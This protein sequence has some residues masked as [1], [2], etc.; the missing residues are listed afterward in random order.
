MIAFHELIQPPNADTYMSSRADALLSDAS[1]AQTGSTGDSDTQTESDRYSKPGAIGK[2][3]ELPSDPTHAVS[4]AAGSPS[5][6]LRE[7]SNGDEQEADPSHEVETGRFFKAEATEL[8]REMPAT[9]LPKPFDP[10]E[11]LDPE[12]AT[13]DQ[14]M[15][16]RNA[17]TTPNF[18]KDEYLDPTPKTPRSD[19]SPARDS[20]GSSLGPAQSNTVG[21]TADSSMAVQHQGSQTVKEVVASE[22]G[23]GDEGEDSKSEIQSIMGQFGHD[24]S[25]SGEDE[26]NSAKRETTSL[27]LQASVQHPP[28]TSSLET[29]DPA[30]P[31]SI[32][33]LGKTGS[34]P[35]YTNDLAQLQL[36]Q[37][38]PGMDSSGRTP[39]NQYPDSPRSARTSTTDAS[40]PMSPQS[41]ISL[42]KAPPPEPDPEPDLPFDFHRFLEQLR[43]RTADP[44]A[45]FLRS[46]LVEFGKKQWMV[47]EQVKI[48]SDFLAFIANKMAQCEV[49]RGV[50]EA[51]F[52]NAK[53]G[54]EKLVMNRLYTQTFSPAI[55]PSPP[56]QE[57]KGKKKDLEKVLG[58]TRKGQHQEDIERD[59]ILGQKVRIYG[60][61]Q[62]EHLD[63]RPVGESG[64]RFLTL[65]QQGYHHVHRSICLTKG[66]QS[67]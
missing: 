4:S 64:R 46:F 12:K 54:M 28:R 33:S 24:G 29:I 3:T 44:V 43:H 7:G 8:E 13:A 20:K 19:Q 34:V 36:Q 26:I 56:A 65:A 41:S 15:S 53:E 52:D 27:G 62:E 40:I 42:P 45:K 38:N 21:D 59:D 1:P 6:R 49:W 10:T 11:V 32:R 50:T 58:P 51:E 47:H 57:S 35:S 17:F 5:S 39:R 18:Q 23:R 63:I 66:S 25:I 16:G 30:N 67:F 22:L 61:V 9:T 37:R 2:S 60:W 55:P 48:I 31:S 14:E